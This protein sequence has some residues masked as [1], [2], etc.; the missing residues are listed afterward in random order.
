[1]V[2][3]LPLVPMIASMMVRQVVVLQWALVP[4]DVTIHPLIVPMVLA[5]VMVSKIVLYPC[6]AWDWD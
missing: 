3:A 4:M 5:L 2:I 6:P 1:M